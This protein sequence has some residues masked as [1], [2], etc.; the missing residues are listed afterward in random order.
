MSQD[1]DNQ[2][3]NMELVDEF[4]ANEND[5]ENVV[6]QIGPFDDDQEPERVEIEVDP[7]VVQN[8]EN[9]NEILNDAPPNFDLANRNRNND[10]NRQNFRNRYRSRRQGRGARSR[11]QQRRNQVFRLDRSIFA[12]VGQ[13]VYELARNHFRDSRGR[14][15]GR[16]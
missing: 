7:Q 13:A 4:L 6:P 1:L 2:L 15:R 9:L 14:G 10:G 16:M 12:G 8:Q 5:N 3:Q 11:H